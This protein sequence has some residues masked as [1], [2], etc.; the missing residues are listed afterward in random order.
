MEN[1]LGGGGGGKWGDRKGTSSRWL[2][3]RK[4]QGPLLGQDP[5]LLWGCDLVRTGTSGRSW[6][7]C[8]FQRKLNPSDF[9]EPILE[10][11]LSY[12]IQN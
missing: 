3:G 12:L 5:G 2:L 4:E 11:L 1:L 6:L 8:A 9:Q 7:P 10:K